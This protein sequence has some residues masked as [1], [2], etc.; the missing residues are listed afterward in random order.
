M[1]ERWPYPQEDLQW[2]EILK[3]IRE[4]KVEKTPG[5]HGISAEMLKYE[6]VVVKWMLWICSLA[7]EQGKRSGDWRKALT[8]PL[9]KGKGSKDK[10]DY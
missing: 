10:S 9:Y 8:M 3:A 1:Q 5:S 4:L 2:G 6:V 7:W